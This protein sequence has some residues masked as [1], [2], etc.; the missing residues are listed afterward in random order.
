M[1]CE[2]Y[3]V[4]AQQIL[5]TAREDVPK[6]EEIRTLIKDIYDIRASKLRTSI[7]AFIKAEGT[8]AKLDNLTS[9]EINTIR[10]MLPHALDH[11]ARYERSAHAAQTDVT[12]IGLSTTGMASRNTTN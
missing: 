11:I 8:Y 10:P 5:S 9:F 3:M 7:D 1:P 12:S 4:V 6:S 2:H